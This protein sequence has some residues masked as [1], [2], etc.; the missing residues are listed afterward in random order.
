MKRFMLALALAS[1]LAGCGGSGEVKAPL[2]IEESLTQQVRLEQAKNSALEQVVQA[3]TFGR[4]Q[5]HGA[6]LDAKHLPVNHR[7]RDL[8][9]RGVHD[10]AESRSRDAH[11]PRGL[12]LVA[13]VEVG[14]PDRLEL[15]Q[16]HDDL[17]EFAQ[18]Y[19]GRLEARE[20][21][22]TGDTA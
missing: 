10:A 13:A 16:G 2:T 20:D 17:L 15:V 4:S 14:E 21:R 22:S 3:T 5:V 9:V 7:I 6:P 1:L 18:R 12:L 19:A 8:P 11:L